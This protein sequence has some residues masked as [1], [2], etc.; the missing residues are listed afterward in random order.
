MCQSQEKVNMGFTNEE[1]P[2][3]THMCLI[4]N[5]EEEREKII[6]KYLQSGLSSSEM[7]AYFADDT[8]KEEMNE[9]L[10]E[11]GIDI[12]NP[13]VSNGFSLHS[14][15]ETYS[16][17][18]KFEVDEM[19]TNLKNLYISAKD[20]NFSAARVTGEI[21][22]ALKGVPGSENLME[23]ES[24]INVL[25][26]KYPVTAICQYDANKFDGATILECFKVH[27]F[28]IV[29]GQIVRNPYYL[30]PEEYLNQKDN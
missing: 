15:S 27:P 24:K 1:F 2:A 25:V 22:W 11:M 19:L 6:S 14:T 16:P 21:S 10:S 23:Y 3:G 8:S 17:N 18:G 13:Q 26:K 28:M 5:K 9:W 30:S 20:K 12:Y 7:V 4:Y 29:P